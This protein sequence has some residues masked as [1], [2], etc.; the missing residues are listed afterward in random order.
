DSTRQ[1]VA[2]AMRRAVEIL[3]R[4]AVGVD[5]R[6][7]LVSADLVADVLDDQARLLRRANIRP[8]ADGVASV[9]RSTRLDHGNVESMKNGRCRGLMSLVLAAAFGCG[10]EAG[11]GTG[12]GTGGAIGGGAGGGFIEDDG[13]TDGGGGGPASGGDSFATATPIPLGEEKQGTI[14]R[15]V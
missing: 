9:W 12:G 3:R 6:L 8:E 15:P 14:E 10:E 1:L 11:V 13:G 7:G 4:G 5:E 2:E